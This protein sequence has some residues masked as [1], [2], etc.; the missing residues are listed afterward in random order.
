MKWVKTLWRFCNTHA[1]RHEHVPV[2][3]NIS[4]FD[5]SHKFVDTTISEISSRTAVGPEMSGPVGEPKIRGGASEIPA[6]RTMRGR[7]S[8]A[9]RLR[10][11]SRRRSPSTAR[12]NRLLLSA[13]S[14]HIDIIHLNSFIIKLG[15]YQMVIMLPD[16]NFNLFILTYVSIIQ[17]T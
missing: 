17:K 2:P 10:Q 1:S 3:R 4:S 13:V 6:P 5:F 16:C 8:S 7:N 14:I 9:P 12:F 11:R 15:S